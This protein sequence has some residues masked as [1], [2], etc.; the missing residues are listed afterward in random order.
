MSDEPAT[1]DR[2]PA[3]PP[4]MPAA[5]PPPAVVSNGLAVA[6]LVLG[7]I[8][9][10]SFFTIVI[11]FVCGVLAIVFGAIGWSRANHGAPSKGIAIAG[12]VC[13]IAGIGLTV[14]FV[15]AVA[16]TSVHVHVGP[17]IS[18]LGGAAFG[19]RQ[20]TGRGVRPARC[21]STR[22]SPS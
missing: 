15:A 8:A 21:T 2:H 3:P 18:P 1:G 12:L 22:V 11:P 14:L 10:V 13:G 6:S 9:I 7:I 17:T 19:P 20:A 16:D 4:A 5:P